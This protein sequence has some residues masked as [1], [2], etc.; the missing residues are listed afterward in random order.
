MIPVLQMKKLR[1]R[2][3]VTH[4]MLHSHEV[5]E[6]GL[7]PGPPDSLAILSVSMVGLGED[8]TSHIKC[9]V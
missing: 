9:S 5:A 6:P 2:E 7:D 8:Q 1:L 3:A 4:L